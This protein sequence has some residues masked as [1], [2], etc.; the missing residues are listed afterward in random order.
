MFTGAGRNNVGISPA[1]APACHSAIAP[2]SVAAPASGRSR[3][4]NPPPRNGTISGNVAK[5]IK[6]CRGAMEKCRPLV[7]RIPGC[8]PLE[9]I[10]DHLV[11]AH[12]LIDRKVAL[13]HA[14]LR[15]EHLDAGLHE[16]SP[17]RG[18]LARRRRQHLFVETE[19]TYRHRLSA[20]LQHNIRTLRQFPQMLSP[21]GKGGAR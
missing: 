2:S 13:E 10:P 11:A 8:E 4:A 19:A 6:T 14:A 16:R 12:A 3:G 20:E 21:V 18:K 1:E 5:P 17:R 9:R 15:A 7:W